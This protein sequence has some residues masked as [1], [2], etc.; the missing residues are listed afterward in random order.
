MPRWGRVLRNHTCGFNSTPARA[1]AAPSPKLAG[2]HF[3]RKRTPP[4]DT[5]RLGSPVGTP[6][7]SFLSPPLRSASCPARFSGSLFPHAG[8]QLKRFGHGLQKLPRELE[9]SRPVGS[10]TG[11]QATRFS[12][13]L[14]RG[15]PSSAAPLSQEMVRP[16]QS[17]CGSECRCNH[18]L[19]ASCEMPRNWMN[20]FFN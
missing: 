7:M 3:P 12:S 14:S 11:F 2:F 10:P 4:R 13:D 20:G 15:V 8:A 9:S 5:A 17:R 16:E 19:L 1:C 6:S 18:C